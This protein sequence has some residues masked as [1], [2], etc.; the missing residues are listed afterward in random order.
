MLLT[1]TLAAGLLAAHEPQDDPP[2]GQGWI[3]NRSGLEEVEPPKARFIIEFQWPQAE[4]RPEPIKVQAIEATYV[5]DLG[6]FMERLK[7]R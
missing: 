5:E 7:K 2:K 1:L 4:P 3:V 6:A